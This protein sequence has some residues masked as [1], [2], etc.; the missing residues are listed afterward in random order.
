MLIYNSL[1]RKREEF[2][3]RVEGTSATPSTSNPSL[4]STPRW[5]RQL[6]ILSLLLVRIRSTHLLLIFAPALTLR[7]LALALYPKIPLFR[8]TVTIASL[9]MA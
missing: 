1:T 9:R 7:R 4:R 5:M 6:A 3:P 8:T 2:V